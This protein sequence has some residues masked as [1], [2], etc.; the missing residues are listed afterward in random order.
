[1]GQQ[2]HPKSYRLGINRRWESRWFNLKE[3]PKLLE[4][5]YKIRQFIYEKAKAC[6]IESIDIERKTKD[7]KIIVKTA[8]P[9]LLIGRQGQG[10]EALQNGL[11]KL[12]KTKSRIDISIE[13]IKHPE[14]SSKIVAQNIAEDLEKRVSYRRVLKQ[15]LTKIMQRKEV[16]GVKIMVSG[17]L[18]GIEIARREWLKEGKL[19]LST[20]R[21]DID[22]GF[23]EAHCTYGMIGIKVWI[24]KGEKF[25]NSD[26]QLNTE[27]LKTL[28]Q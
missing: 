21:A 27:K 7:I 5:D 19:P 1:M 9:G 10:I 22:Y 28:R 12:L 18:G 8:R 16:L 23:T 3:A 26:K 4:E 14:I 20:L 13:E 17:R 6:R 24:Y 15:Y 11:A 25:L 2:I